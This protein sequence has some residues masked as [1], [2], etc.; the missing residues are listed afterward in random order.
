MHVDGTNTGKVYKETAQTKRETKKDI[1]F[2]YTMGNKT[3]TKSHYSCKKATTGQKQKSNKAW[4]K[5]GSHR[6]KLREKNV[7]VAYI[8]TRTTTGGLVKTAL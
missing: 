1:K 4:Q 2:K 3:H 6:G 8:Y 5:Q 7:T